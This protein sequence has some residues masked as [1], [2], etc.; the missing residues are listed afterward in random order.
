MDRREERGVPPLFRKG[1]IVYNMRHGE[2]LQHRGAVLP[3]R[4]LHVAGYLDH[5]GLP[6]GWMAVFD[7]D[8]SK[9]W[10]EKIFTRD[11]VVDGKTLHIIGL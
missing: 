11:E 5:L 3:G 9:S 8:A 1:A 7:D 10:D 4:T 6:E 2:M